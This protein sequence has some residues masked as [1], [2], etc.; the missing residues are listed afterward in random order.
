MGQADFYR[1]GS[2]NFICDRCGFKFKA[3]KKHFEW[4]G[5][6]VCPDCYDER[7]PQDFVRST[8]DRQHVEDPRPEN[9]D[10]FLAINEITEADLA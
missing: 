3:E 10:Y 2:H 5:L 1:H 6:I 9:E 7:H 4:T 8:A